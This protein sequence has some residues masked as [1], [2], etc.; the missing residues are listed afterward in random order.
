MGALPA[1]DAAAI[2]LAWRPFEQSLPR[3]LATARGVLTHKR[4]WLLRLSTA[5]GGV[6]WGEAAPLAFGEALMP[7]LEALAAAIQDLGSV[8]SRL[9]L[10]R[11]LAPGPGPNAWPPVLA[12]ALG[13]ALA[14]VDGLVGPAGPG[15]LPAPPA[16][17]LLPAGPDALH[18]LQRLLA[19]G[20]LACPVFKWKVG[21]H[22]DPEE[23]AVLEALLQRLPLQ[24]RLRLDANG[25][26]DRATAAQWAARLVAEPRLQ[27]LEQ[28]LDPAD[29]EGLE[30]LAALVPVAL[31][32]SL[33]A[34]P[35]LR[36][37]WSGWQVRRPSQEGDPRPLLAGLASGQ[38]R[39]VLSSAFETGIA[40]RW[41]H[42]LA[43]LQAQ[44]PLPVTPG[45]AQAWQGAGPLGADDPQTVWEAAV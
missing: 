34:N 18:G 1:A 29:Q 8:R 39:L 41:L 15:W 3:P 37:R 2:A 33:D 42:H 32:E 14:E 30:Q 35:Q 17:W 45:L 9:E 43:G 11:G 20:P 10:E 40:R 38:R 23:R 25:C 44:S 24:A 21:V 16:A 5:A 27:W 36:Q 22:S 6:G 19:D 28:P 12:F 26:W 31:D 4:G 13:S 7:A